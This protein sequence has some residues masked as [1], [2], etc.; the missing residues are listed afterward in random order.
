MKYK[1]YKNSNN[2][3]VKIRV[4]EN[5]GI[6]DVNRYLNPSDS[7]IINYNL[8]SNMNVAV[9]CFAK[10]FNNKSPIAI[11]VDSDVDGYCS[12]AMMYLY[13]KK[14][15]S[16]YPVSYILHKKAKA[17]G[18]SEDVVIPEGTKL[19]IIPDASTN[20]HEQCKKIKEQ[21]IDII[22][23]DHHEKEF[24]NPHAIIVNNQI[25]DDYEN[26]DFSGAGIVYKFLL[27]LDSE[28]WVEYA[29]EFLDLCAWANISDDMDMRSYETKHIVDKGLS[30]IQNE[31]LKALI[32]A[33]EFSL[34]GKIN[35]HNVQW[36]LTPVLNGMIRIGSDEDKELVFRAMIGD[37][38][39]FD[40]KKRGQTEAI[41][42]N[43]FDRAARI[44]KNAKSRQDN[45]RKNG[46]SKIIEVLGEQNPENKVVVADVTT[47]LD[48]GLTGVVAIKVAE[49]FNKPCILLKEMKTNDDTKVFGGSMRNFDNSPIDSFKD[50][51]NS[52]P[53]FN[54]CMGHPNAAGISIN[55]D[56]VENGIQEL[57]ERLK[58]VIYDTTY[59]VDFIKDMNDVDFVLINEM[60]QLENI[61]AKGIDTP[62]IAIE[63]I[64]LRKQ[65]FAVKGKNADTLQ[66][67]FNDI[68]FII[69]GANELL[70]W[71][72]NCWDENEIVM[73]DLVGEPK[74]NDFNGVRTIQVNIKDINFNGTK[75]GTEED[76]EDD[77]EAGW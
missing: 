2:E 35:I 39:E 49:H 38:E 6:K 61:V 53:S 60:A 30:N 5:R 8:L 51:I 65:D 50:I 75:E 62:L 74:I 71:F 32:R 56:N 58:D 43:I 24:D 12:A 66:F 16:Y 26:K 11:L 68:E 31:F 54:Y 27:A 40:Y 46:I 52:C 20:D 28:F 45:N 42:E 69:F 25:S 4:L 14:L 22:I 10:H 64:E 15:D 19:L 41:K 72:D 18:L 21:G 3:N 77:E 55:A 13:I 63:N 33:Q 7:E 73:F 57:N 67:S 48:E 23:L 37:Y 9:E 76:I 29:D 70:K 36:Y 47:I 34:K 59:R 44:S 1:L 17:H